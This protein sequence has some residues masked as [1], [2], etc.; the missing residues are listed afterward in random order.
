[1]AYTI[2]QW[3]K[4]I[5]NRA[6]MSSF[7]FHLTK[8]NGSLTSTDVLLKILKERK[9]IGSDSSGF[10]G[11][12]HTAVCFQD[13][14]AYGL[15]QNT[16]HEQQ[17]REQNSSTKLRYNPVGIGLPKRYLYTLKGARPVIYE[18]KETARRFIPQEEW[19][20]I[21]DFDLG[22]AD[23]IVDWTH[24]REWRVKG[25]MTFKLSEAIVIIPTK[26]TYRTF[27]D[28]ADD[29][30]IKGIGGITVLDPVLS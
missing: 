1:M 18:R 17:L 25:D 30:I 5:R 8:P 3:R 10:I 11:G 21:V 15:S 7:L 19:W 13:V 29:S 22:N 4:R 6:D 16:Y 12:R 24:E 27:M 26:E 14:P 23:N 2:Q 20:R 28:K 9:L